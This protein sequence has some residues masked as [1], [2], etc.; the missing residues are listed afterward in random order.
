MAELLSLP[1]QF[2]CVARGVGGDR[3]TDSKWLGQQL[4]DLTACCSLKGDASFSNALAKDNMLK[5]SVQGDPAFVQSVNG[6]IDLPPAPTRSVG[7]AFK[8][9]FT[10]SLRM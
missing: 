9:R 1:D 7:Q 10:R 2:T 3:I 8:N 4:K 6:L 5:Q